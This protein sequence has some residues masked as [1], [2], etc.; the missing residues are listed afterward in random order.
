MTTTPAHWL[1]TN[2]DKAFAEKLY[3]SFVPVFFA[4]NAV[5]QR[6]GWLDVG[7][8][9]HVVQNLGMWLP[10]CVLLPAWLRRHSGVPVRESYWVK[11]NVWMAVWVFFATY[12]HTE[13]FF[14][15]FHMRY[16]FPLVT[17]YFDSALLGP[18]EATAAAEWKK[19]PVGMYL[20]T[21]AFF[22]VYH[23]A[24][25]VCMRRVRTMTRPSDTSKSA[26]RAGH[27]AARMLGGRV[28]TTSVV[29][30]SVFHILTA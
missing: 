4:Y 23:V 14:E 26:H 8:S 24:A 28:V 25:V 27:S 7:N 18:D 22:T 1:S 12:F 11:F 30:W 17:W 9:W 16:R 3:L 10:Y 5:V 20:N 15:L 19:V 21:M 29:G 2:E 6:L 13:Y